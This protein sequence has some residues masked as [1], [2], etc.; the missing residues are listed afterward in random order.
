MPRRKLTPQEKEK[1]QA[2]RREA[3]E[4]KERARKEL[5]EN[6]QFVNPKFWNSLDEDLV[7][8]IKTSIAKG[9][10][11]KDLKRIRKLENELSELRDKVQPE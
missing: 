6:P 4:Q 2:A 10:R 5:E 9:E 8:K 3:R 7:K 11:A 1:M